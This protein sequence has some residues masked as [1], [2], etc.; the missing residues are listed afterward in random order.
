[1]SQAPLWDMNCSSFKSH[2]NDPCVPIQFWRSRAPTARLNARVLLGLFAGLVNCQFLG[3]AGRAP[4][5]FPDKQDAI[6]SAQMAAG[7]LA[8]LRNDK[9]TSSARALPAWSVRH[10]PFPLGPRLRHNIQDAARNAVA[11][12]VCAEIHDLEAVGQYRTF[13]S[14]LYFSVSTS[15]T[16]PS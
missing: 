5:A 4:V 9:R 8:A 7:D 3:K 1:M 11:I 13:L 14:V 10:R 12:L 15:R 6:R 16:S 2:T